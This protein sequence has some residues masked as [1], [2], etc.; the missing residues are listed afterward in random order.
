MSENTENFAAYVDRMGRRAK[1]AARTLRTASAGRK[2]AALEAAAKNLRDRAQEIVVANAVDVDRA[3]TD[4]RADAYIDR[5]LL[6]IDRVDSIANAVEIVST[7]DDPVGRV[8]SETVR[9]NGL[10]IS[11]VATPIGVIAMIY[12]SRPNVGADAGALCI[13]S[14]N[15]VILRGGSDSAHS[16]GIIAEC[17]RDGLKS[18]NL[19]IDAIQQ[20]DLPDRAIVACLLQATTHVD[21]AIPRGG[22]SLVELV[23]QQARVATLLHL[24]GNCHTYIHSSAV[25]GD[26]IEIVANAKLRRTGVCGAT[27]SIVI[28]RG[29][30]EVFIPAILNRL[31]GCEV[32]GDDDAQ[33]VDP[34]VVA[35]SECDWSTEYL[36]AIVSMKVVDGFNEAVDFIATHS[37]GHTDAIVTTDEAAAERFLSE[38]DS[39]VLMWNT[40][41][42]F[43]D[44]GE[45]GMGAEIGIATGRLHARGPVG[46]EQLTTYKWLVRGNGQLR[47]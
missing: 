38:L 44:G 20:V 43:S 24:E 21:L 7:L 2:N 39:A 5:L 33:A 12:E 19:P 47:P 32:R 18:A 40:S 27:E 15:A 3:R 6:T 34:R 25:L 28:D 29:I 36:D 41:T 8:L 30:A 16:S 17:M 4:G 22:R 14:G 46:L 35:A 23:Q 10:R 31:E 9:P 13:K 37:S 11:R 26:A 45:F 42:Q 1:A